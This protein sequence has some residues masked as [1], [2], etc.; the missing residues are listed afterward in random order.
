METKC[1]LSAWGWRQLKDTCDRELVT[2]C[3][4]A[5]GSRDSDAFVKHVNNSTSGAQ[6]FLTM[7]AIGLKDSQSNEL[8]LQ[9]FA[10]QAVKDCAQQKNLLV[11]KY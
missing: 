1:D 5:T 3:S 11:N 10:S 6:N 2:A 7:N 4:L 8:L 9:L